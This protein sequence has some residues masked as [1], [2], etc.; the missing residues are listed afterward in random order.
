MN[1]DAMLQ[2]EEEVLEEDEH[3]PQGVVAVAPQSMES[4][5]HGLEAED[6]DEE[7]DEDER[8][9]V[10]PEW[11][12]ES[13]LLQ[14]PSRSTSF[15][16]SRI[17]ST[18]FATAQ[19]GEASE[20]VSVFSSARSILAGTNAVGS[21]RISNRS[22]EVPPSHPTTPSPRHRQSPPVQSP[23]SSTPR[24]SSRQSAIHSPAGQSSTNH[25]P[26][27]RGDVTSVTAQTPMPPG[28]WASSVNGRRVRFSPASRFKQ[29]EGEEALSPYVSPENPRRES[30]GK[31]D[32][33]K[34]IVPSHVAD[35]SFTWSSKLAQV[36]RLA[37]GRQDE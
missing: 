22:V 1:E 33:A 14:Q 28:G 5:E 16:R 18:S 12:D 34:E 26:L 7:D 8:V 32:E 3:L 25:T 24:G 31:V 11:V 13:Q 9:I 10:E 6:E 17:S 35:G 2:E 20:H 36:R 37:T 4:F 23:A 30:S 27:R 29:E 21:S 15:E 19:N